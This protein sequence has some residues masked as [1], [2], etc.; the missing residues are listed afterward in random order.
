MPDREKVI[1][2]AEEAI[3]ILGKV[4][5]PT[6]WCDFVR[7]AFE[8]TLAL[9]KEQE[10]VGWINVKDRLPDS[11]GRYLCWYGKNKVLVGADIAEYL[12][13]ARAFWSFEHCK[14]IENITHWMPL[15]EMPK[16][17]NA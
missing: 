14:A 12:V 5:E 15:P 11:N 4:E 6:F 10:V 7:V 3:K 8:N 1:K 17:E 2:E 9:L 16:G 13:E